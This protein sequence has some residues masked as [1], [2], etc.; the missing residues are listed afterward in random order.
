M[1]KFELFI[2]CLS[3]KSGNHDGCT[4]RKPEN[5]NDNHVEIQC[6]CDACSMRKVV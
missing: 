4:K 2:V 3:C 5:S 1:A 6:I